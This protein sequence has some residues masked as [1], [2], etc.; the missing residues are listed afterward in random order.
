MVEVTEFVAQESPLS[1]SVQSIVLV[2]GALL[3]LLVFILFLL[4]TD[5]G[6]A[7]KDSKSCCLSKKRSTGVVGA[8]PDSNDDDGGVGNSRGVSL[9][10]VAAVPVEAQGRAIP[11][12]SREAPEA[13]EATADRGAGYDRRPT[14]IGSASTTTGGTS[15][16]V[17]A[18]T[19]AAAAAASAGGTAGTMGSSKAAD[20]TTPAVIEWNGLSYAVPKARG[21]P[22]GCLTSCRKPDLAVLSDVSGF[23]GPKKLPLPAGTAKIATAVVPGSLPHASSFSSSLSLAADGSLMGSAM[24]GMGSPAGPTA[25]AP[26]PAVAANEGGGMSVGGYGAGGVAGGQPSTLTGL[27]G[28]SGA[29]KSSLL[30]ILAGRKR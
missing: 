18:A 3:L 1:T 26:S 27:L 14:S 21:G 16:T 4:A 2:V 15:G 25:V 24:N 12:S 28:P 23:A 13:E 11:S 8:S 17:T 30:D 5:W 7:R 10:I 6:S 29:G 20:F 9:P 19:A 22:L